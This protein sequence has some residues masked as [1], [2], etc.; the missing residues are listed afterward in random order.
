MKWN[1]VLAFV[2]AFIIV[3][4]GVA[5][6]AHGNLLL[7]SHPQGPVGIQEREVT[8]L[9]L[10]LPLIV[11]IPVLF[12]LFFFAV[13]YHASSK[14]AHEKHRPNWDHDNWIA[15]VI[16]WF[17]PAMIIMVLAV[18]A[19]QSSYQLDPYKPLVS[20]TPP[21]TI[22]VV[23]LDWKWLFIYP[24]QGI[25]SVNTLVFP[26]NTPL[27]FELTSDAPMN[28]FWIPSLGGQI[29]TMPGMQTQLNLMADGV[30]TYHGASANISGS[31]FAG[32]EFE[33]QSVTQSDFDAW[34]ASAK[35]VGGPLS[36]QTYEALAKP[37]EYVPPA[38]YLL[39]D[40]QLY[41]EIIQNQ[42]QPGSVSKDGTSTMPMHGMDMSGMSM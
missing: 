4:L 35:E 2:A 1:I 39:T 15:E 41:T 19:W 37:S 14:N 16:W 38:R 20:D 22:Q 12:L 5:A 42:M 36:W 7:L 9:A 33:A 10:L 34:V 24:E 8:N 17:V 6:Y 11:I 13:K 31:G 27:H 29:M 30:G 23:S 26:E 40:G 21:L 18:V 25:A 3:G 28:S 32:M